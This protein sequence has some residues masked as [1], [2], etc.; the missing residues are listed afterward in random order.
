M[1]TLFQPTTAAEITARL[2]K[3]GPDA[4]PL[5]GKMNA[6]QMMA[7]CQVPFETYLG[8][9]TL[10]HSLMGKLFGRMAKRKLFSDKP[11]PKNLPTAKE[12]I[13]SD[14]RDLARERQKLVELV[15]RFC[16]EEPK[17]TA[18]VHPFFGTLT[19]QEWAALAQRHLEH[20]L[21]QFGV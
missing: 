3:I 4:K 18:P 7:H 9:R 12:F 16:A 21:Q 8:N 11:W 5:W 19:S 1:S 2:E 10:K 13:V 20:H 15:N 14:E 17:T 6:A